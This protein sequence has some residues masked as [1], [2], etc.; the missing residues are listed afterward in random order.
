MSGSFIQQHIQLIYKDDP[1]THVHACSIPS[2]SVTQLSSE[3]ASASCRMVHKSDQS[4]INEGT[5]LD[6]KF[7]GDV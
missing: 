1:A 6:L 2:I 7:P 4:S 3:R 5:D